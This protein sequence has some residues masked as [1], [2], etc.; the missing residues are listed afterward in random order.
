MSRDR[1]AEGK[2]VEFYA[3]HVRGWFDSRMKADTYYINLAIMW[4]FLL[5][6]RGNHIGGWFPLLFV[7]NLV[8]IAAVL[9]VWHFN[10]IYIEKV[11]AGGD[12]APE[13]SRVLKYLDITVRVASALVAVSSTGYLAL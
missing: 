10:T 12:D 1:V 11:I 6:V 8:V 7:V 3:A 5:A 13:S 4:C 2:Q 9:A